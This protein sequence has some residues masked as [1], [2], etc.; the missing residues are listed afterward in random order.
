[1]TARCGLLAIH[2]WRQ[3]MV[4]THSSGSELSSVSRL[5]RPLPSC[6]RDESDWFPGKAKVLPSA[7]PLLLPSSLDLALF[8]RCLRPE[9]SEDSLLPAS[10]LLLLSSIDLRRM[11]SVSLPIPPDVTGRRP[12]PESP[13]GSSLLEL[14]TRELVELFLLGSLSP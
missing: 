2:A 13:F 1:M 4:G 6:A 12:T 7:F 9:R 3:Q 11:R 10:A 14:L 5:L 8:S